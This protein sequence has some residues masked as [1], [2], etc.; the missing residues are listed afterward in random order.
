[1]QDR[2]LER[3]LSDNPLTKVETI[4][5]TTKHG[6]VQVAKQGAANRTVIVTFHD[7]AYNSATQFHHFFSFTEMMSITQCFTIYHINA[8][9]QEDRAVPLPI[10]QSYP[11]MEQMAEIVNDVFIHFDIKSAIGF[12]VGAGANVLARFALLQPS[13]IYGLVLI[14]CISRAIGWFEGFSIKET[15][16]THSDLVQ[17]LRRHL[18]ENVNAKNVIKYLNSFFKCSVINVTGFTSPHKDDVVDTNDKCDPAKSS[19]VEFSDCGGFVLEEQPA[20][21][22]ESFRLFLQGLGYLSH[23]SIPRYSIAGRLAEQSMEFKKK[24]GDNTGAPRRLSAPFDSQDYM[25]RRSSQMYDQEL[26]L[27]VD[28]FDEQN[29]KL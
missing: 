5:V 29:V 21:M 11:T 13:K 28:S 2:L 9:G 26:T 17:S 8:P 16:S 20:K 24:H 18:E 22:A 23:L 27:V 6:P 15:Q 12:G 3:S 10:N 7:I 1:M 4:T 14:N 19:L 25:P